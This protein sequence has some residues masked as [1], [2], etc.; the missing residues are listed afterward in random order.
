MT[1]KRR[2][3]NSKKDIQYGLGGSAGSLIGTLAGVALAP[4]TGGLSIPAATAI[5]GALGGGTGNII[6]EIVSKGKGSNNN[7]ALQQYTP[8]TVNMNPYGMKKG[9][10]VKRYPDGG[11]IKPP[12]QTTDPNKVRAYNDSLQLHNL[13]KGI[14]D[15]ML[16]DMENGVLP[17]DKVPYHINKMDE[18]IPETDSLVNDLYDM[19]IN[20]KVKG[21]N[22]VPIG[23]NGNFTEIGK[24]Q[25]VAPKPTQPYFYGK[26]GMTP[27]TPIDIQLGEVRVGTDQKGLSQIKEK[28]YNPNVFKKHAKKIK[29]ENP[30][31]FVLADEGDIIISADMVDRY[32]QIDDIGRKSI[33]RK[34]VKRQEKEKPEQLGIQVSKR[35]G[36][37]AR[38]YDIGGGLDGFFSDDYQSGLDYLQ[39]PF[40]EPN[41]NPNETP[42]FASSV[43]NRNNFLPPSVDPNDTFYIN[44]VDNPEQYSGNS[45]MNKLAGPGL[46]DNPY[47]TAPSA[48][49]TSGFTPDLGSEP[50]SVIDKLMGNSGRIAPMAADIFQIVNS[51]KKDKVQRVRNAG[52]P[53]ALRTIDQMETTVNIDPALNQ[54]NANFQAQ[55]DTIGNSSNAAIKDARSQ[56]AYTN[57]T[58]ADQALVGEKIN[59]ETDL[60]NNKRQ[61]KANIQ[62]QGGSEQATF[63]DQFNERT[64]LNTAAGRNIQNA[65]MADIATKTSQ[66]SS[67]DKYHKIIATAMGDYYDVDPNNLWVGDDLFKK[68]PKQAE[69]L[70][71]FVIPRQ[72]WAKYFSKEI[73]DKFDTEFSK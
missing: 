9:G 66:F 63:D 7:N 30:A 39:E 41:V 53:Q 25:K 14:Y 29:D 17:I 15:G 37:V 6:E 44:P 8:P 49:K 32:S 22:K 67:E 33:E 26:G 42:N 58:L 36:V 73:M 50:T 35:G 68:D 12:I 69:T 23:S 59:K 1:K 10:K 71:R 5:G 72:Q 31:N 13:T 51:I 21:Y 16:E 27:Q 2:K 47:I 18:I 62:F 43:V 70:A 19:G 57:K 65:A 61:A 38:R 64:A 45:D 55:L 40:G 28:Y 11:I 3:Y 34:L 46:I 54:N 4:L 56:Q 20:Y 52:F 48:Q 24:L 60:R